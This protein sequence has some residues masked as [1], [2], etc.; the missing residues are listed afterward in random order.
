MP[1]L[2]A[3]WSDVISEYGAT[4]L[5]HI[6]NNF[7][8]WYLPCLFMLR[9]LVPFLC[10]LRWPVTLSFAVSI[11][12]RT[13]E[14]NVLF[15]F[16]FFVLGFSLAGGGKSQEERT[17]RLQSLEDFLT[18]DWLRIVAFAFVIAW[19]TFMS[20]AAS[21]LVDPL[22]GYLGAFERGLVPWSGGG[23]FADL[24]LDA[25]L[26]VLTLCFIVICF[27]M[28]TVVYDWASGAGSRTLYVYVLHLLVI[29]DQGFS[30]DAVNGLLGPFSPRGELLLWGVQAIFFT[31]V[32]G[33][34][35]TE[36]LTN[37]FVQPQW[38][39]DLLMWPASVRSPAKNTKPV[40]EEGVQ[41]SDLLL[42]VTMNNTPLKLPQT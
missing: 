22:P 32:L 38:L 31:F 20:S 3:V 2:G 35:F 18:N 8:Y 28:P 34:G 10:M 14:V 33:S 27:A 15:L 1:P 24:A 23:I 21:S 13:S 12:F 4:A 7:Y 37:A 40:H 26:V 9:L 36:W 11:L 16:P 19:V 39:L 17:A 30:H 29:D 41:K 6:P 42:S 5:L 25:F